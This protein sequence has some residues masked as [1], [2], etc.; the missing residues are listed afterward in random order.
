MAKSTAVLPAEQLR[1]VGRTIAR[2]DARDKVQA[3]TLYAADWQMPGMLH[4]RHAGRSCG[5][6][7]AAARPA[8]RRRS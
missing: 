4:G 6:P 7:R 3:S 1:V 8:E 2:H 5:R